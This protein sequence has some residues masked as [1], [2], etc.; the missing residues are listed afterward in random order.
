MDYFI[1]CVCVRSFKRTT[2][3][4]IKKT[5]ISEHQ[6]CVSST[7]QQPRWPVTWMQKLRISKVSFLLFISSL[8]PFSSFYLSMLLLMCWWDV[9]LPWFQMFPTAQ[10]P[11]LACC[12]TPTL[13]HSLMPH[14]AGPTHTSKQTHTDK[15]QTNGR[16]C[17]F[18]VV[19]LHIC[20]HVYKAYVCESA[21]TVY[22]RTR[23]L[24]LPAWDE[25]LPVASLQTAAGQ[26]RY[27]PI[28]YAE[29]ECRKLA[30]LPLGEKLR[31][32]MRQHDKFIW[33]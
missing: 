23:Q 10:M 2:Y 24:Q 13:Y 25:K 28:S 30:W 21:E 22:T 4:L 1:Y 18:K 17:W 19:C 29:A 26:P 14:G 20:V 16:V 31:N 27:Q 33:G 32:I 11:G 15:A 6:C 3:Y 5:A 8:C 7:H 12:Y 9:W